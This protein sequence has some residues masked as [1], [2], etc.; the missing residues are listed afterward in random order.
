[1][2]GDVLEIIFN[3]LFEIV[4]QLLVEALFEAGFHGLAKAL[5]HRVVRA[6]LGVALG[7]AIGFGGGYW[8]GAR[9]TEAGRTDPPTSLWISIALALAFAVLAVVRLL[10]GRDWSEQRRAL[11]W[12]W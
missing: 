5:G 9:L 12:R 11:P 4:G 7:A 1:T 8:W 10:R 6:V 3:L 2:A